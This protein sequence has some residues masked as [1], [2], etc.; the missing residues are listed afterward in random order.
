MCIEII[1]VIFLGVLLVTTPQI[2]AIEVAKRGATMF[3]KLKVPLIG[4]IENMHHVTCDSCTNKIKIFGDSTSQLAKDLSC[5]ILEQFP[6]NP[7]ISS[8]TDDGTPIVIK[9]K[10]N[11][12]SLIY[13]R[14][15]EK[16]VN[17]LD[18]K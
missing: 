1:P 6:L 16:V 18:N 13:L 12:I 9:D 5:D 11:E 4:I 8:C 17:F 14:L 15:A 7:V 2:A 3:K 10:D